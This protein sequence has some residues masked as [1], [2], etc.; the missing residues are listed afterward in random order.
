MH[1]HTL[2]RSSQREW[3]RNGSSSC[4]LFLSFFPLVFSWFLC[5]WCWCCCC[6]ERNLEEGDTMRRIKWIC[7]KVFFT[8]T[9]LPQIHSNSD[10]NSKQTNEKIIIYLNVRL[11][12]SFDGCPIHSS[13]E[14]DSKKHRRWTVSI[15]SSSNAHTRSHVCESEPKSC[16][17]CVTLIIFPS[18]ACT[19]SRLVQWAQ[20]EQKW[21]ETKLKWNGEKEKNVR[22]E[23][24]R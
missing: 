14:I 18:N 24:R 21:D 3:E 15:Y 17:N 1:M 11:I 7:F 5:E 8:Q 10:S 19:F 16:E 6:L 4:V 22:T 23:W 2:H 20:C 12:H 13:D 9:H